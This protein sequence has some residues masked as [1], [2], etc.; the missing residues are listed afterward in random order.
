MVFHMFVSTT[1][2]QYQRREDQTLALLAKHGIEHKNLQTHGLCARIGPKS[3]EKYQTKINMTKGAMQQMGIIKRSKIK[4]LQ[5]HR[6]PL[7]PQKSSA[8]HDKLF[9]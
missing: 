7:L 5:M 8:R 6:R 2:T 3:P 4:Y 9:N 1:K